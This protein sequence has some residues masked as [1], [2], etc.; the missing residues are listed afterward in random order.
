MTPSTPPAAEPLDAG[1]DAAFS[2]FAAMEDPTSDQAWMNYLAL[3]RD[4][5][6]VDLPAGSFVSAVKAFVA[7]HNRA[8]TAAAQPKAKADKA[9][10]KA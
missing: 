6:G 1:V 9:P 3:L 2:R 10:T 7:E 4:E 5:H 8:L